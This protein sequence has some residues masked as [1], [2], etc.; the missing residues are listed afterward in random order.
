MKHILL[1]GAGNLG[2]RYLQGM[3]DIS[4]PVAITVVDPSR[5]SLNAAKQMWA[6]SSGTL[7]RRK[8]QLSKDLRAI[9]TVI[10]LVVV[11]TTADVRA[12]VVRRIAEKSTVHYW[13]LEKVLAQSVEQISQISACVVG[14]EKCWVNMPRRIMPWHNE[15]RSHLR[16]RGPLHV[17]R[18]GSNWGLACNGV[19]FID[20]VSWW[21]SESPTSIGTSNLE[22][23][24]FPSKRPGFYEVNGSIEVDYS[25]GTR[26]TLTSDTGLNDSELRV[27]LSSGEEWTIDEAKGV[28]RS[29]NNIEIRGEMVY[30]SNMT[31][32]LVEGILISNKCGLTGLGDAVVMHD[33]LL[34]E[35]GRHYN[36]Y[37]GS[38]MGV[39][40]IT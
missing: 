33:I 36:Q 30:Q 9:E 26:L 11:T 14:S 15:I 10:D 37:S 5:E 29:S 17:T 1:V 4:V 39:L 20:L 35:L 8:L 13:I 19:H 23:E 6:R 34:K 31:R 32:S 28:A 3:S 18:V 38:Y 25:L 22:K 24:W 12:D 40:P 7:A 2:I 21:T 27:S 16:G